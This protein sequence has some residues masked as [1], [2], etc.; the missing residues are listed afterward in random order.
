MPVWL[1]VILSILAVVLVAFIVLMI[2]GA[3]LQKKANS[4]QEALANA[5]QT[6]SMLIIDKKKLKITEANLPK[7]V[8]DQVPKYARR[9]KFPIVKARVVGGGSKP[10]NLI[11]DAA[12]FDILPVGKE[13]KVVVSGIYITEIKSV[14]GGVIP[15]PPKKKGLAGLMQKASKSAKYTAKDNNK[16]AKDKPSKTKDA[17]ADKN[18]AVDNSR[19]A[20]KSK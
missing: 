7:V 17:K 1:T 6:V 8:T 13:C 2:V 18:E 10:M 16:A 9:A 3:R 15:A 12:V 14:R 11:A 4:Q 20:K 19:K 5:A